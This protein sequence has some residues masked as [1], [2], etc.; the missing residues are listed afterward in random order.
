M[1]WLVGRLSDAERQLG[2]EEVLQ[3]MKRFLSGSVCAAVSASIAVAAAISVPRAAIAQTVTIDGQPVSGAVARAGNLMIPFR[4]P[5]EHIGA[6]VNYDKPTATASMGGQQLVQITTGDTNAT[7]RGNPRLLATAPQLVNGVEYVPVNVLSGICGA[8]VAY[9]GD[10][11]TATITHCTLAGLNRVALAAPSIA[12]PAVPPVAAPS[13][14]WL[15]WLIGLLCLLAL[16]ALIA[17]YLNRRQRTVLT[18]NVY[19]QTGRVAPET[20]PG[21]PPTGRSVIDDPKTRP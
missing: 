18:T 17:W 20:T 7:I 21:A 12:A 15:P 1:P 16:L 2:I 5:M 19:S 13:F 14:N 10:R 4:A 8:T 9:S 11:R 3:I 6:T